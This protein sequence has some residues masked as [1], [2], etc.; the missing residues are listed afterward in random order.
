MSDDS[1]SRIRRI[2]AKSVVEHYI[3]ANGA[4]LSEL[5]TILRDYAL[6]HKLS[7]GE[8]TQSLLIMVHTSVIMNEVPAELYDG[9]DLGA[10]HIAA[11]ILDVAES[12]EKPN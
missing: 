3:A 2:D 7:G 10:A 5:S 12:T 9:L 1:D 4:R 11:A 8:V 6:R